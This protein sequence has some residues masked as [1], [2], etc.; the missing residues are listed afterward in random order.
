MPIVKKHTTSKKVKAT[1]TVVVTKTKEP[2]S[3]SAFAKKLE[4]VNNL[5]AKSSLLN[6]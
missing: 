5:L 6:S 2:A 1:K 4:K 3:K